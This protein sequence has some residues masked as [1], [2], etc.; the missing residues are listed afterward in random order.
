MIYIST[1][2]IAKCSIDNEEKL[3]KLFGVNAEVLIDHAWG[4]EPV[5]IRDIK[6]YKPKSNCITSGQV[7]H[8]PY[9]YKKTKLIV[10]EMADLLAL[11]LVRKHLVTNKI[12]L[13][14]GY[15][16]ENI[17][18]CNIDYDGEVTI[19]HYGRKVPKHAHGTTSLEY[20]TSSSK[21]I[22]DE[23]MNSII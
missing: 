23:V 15:D 14:I 16:I 12:V 4:W 6:S 22:T 17:T 20:R 2:Y 13:T 9:D 1:R 11:D 21:I 8:C 18:N 5:T 7:L 10:R 19:D 3:Y